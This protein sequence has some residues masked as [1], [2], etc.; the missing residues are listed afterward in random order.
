MTVLTENLPSI[1]QFL[2]L[3]QLRRTHRGFDPDREVPEEYIQ[4]VLEAARWA[5]SG[6]NSQPW[7]FLVIRDAADRLWNAEL[8]HKQHESKREM[9]IAVRGQVRLTGAGFKH[10]PVH[11]LVL[12]DPRVH[13]AY[14][15][16]TRLEKSARH[17]YSGLASA[18]LNLMLAAT[19]LGLVTQFVSDS[20]SPYMAT[21]LKVHYGIPDPLEIY[22][23]VPIG[24]PAADTKPTPRRS[25]EDIVHWDRF[26]Q[27][28]LLT[29]EEMRQFAW[30]DTRLGAFGKG[31]SH[32]A[33]QGGFFAES[34]TPTGDSPEGT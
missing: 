9:E 22:E 24:W 30:H 34:V 8:F 5:P 31:P 2:H 29:D 15:I 18:T 13:E 27:A 16:R 6:G 11:V 4:Q 14:P 19:T 7:L 33:I 12:G 28:K 10:A 21:M 25:L 3:A 1:E 32:S 17:F 23:M 26:D 20:C